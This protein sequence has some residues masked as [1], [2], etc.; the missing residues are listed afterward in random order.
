LRGRAAHAKGRKASDAQTQRRG[1]DAYLLHEIL[2][3][4]LFSF[5]WLGVINY[6]IVSV[7]LNLLVNAWLCVPLTPS[8][9]MAKEPLNFNVPVAPFNLPV[10]LATIAVPE[11]LTVPAA[12]SGAAPDELLMRNVS[13][14]P[15]P[16]SLPVPVKWKPSLA[17]VAGTLPVPVNLLEP[18]PKSVAV[19]LPVTDVTLAAVEVLATEVRRNVKLPL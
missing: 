7:P 2:H 14:L 15:A 3:Y 5:N 9:E 1:A 12:F 6:L 19:P 16:M 17:A 18:V 11:M 4:V 8:L 13:V 10:P